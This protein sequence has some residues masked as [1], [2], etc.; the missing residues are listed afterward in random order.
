MMRKYV[1]GSVA[2]AMLLGVLSGCAGGAQP[3][4]SSAPGSSTAETGAPSSSQTSAASSQSSAPGELVT[5]RL[6][7][8]GV[9]A[10]SVPQ[11]VGLKHDIY[12]KY[13]IDLQVI[14]FVK[15]GAEAAAA[16][17]SG[18]V[19]MGSYGS[20]ILTAISKDVPI[21][22]VASPPNKRMDF[23]LTARNGIDKVEDLRGKTI[24]TGALGGGQHQSL[25]T[26]LRAHGLTEQDVNVVATGGA[27]FTMILGSGQVDAVEAGSIDRFR[28]EHEGFGHLLAE[29]SDYYENY[30][31][32]YIYATDAFI[33]AHPDAVT[34]FLKA[35]REVMQY[36]VDNLDEVVTAAKETVNLDEEVLG[37]YYEDTFSKW[38]LTFE[39]D[40]PGIANAVEILKGL[41]E[42]ESDVTFDAA[43]WVD[44][45]FLKAS[46]K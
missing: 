23:E 43:T 4:G 38:D 45:R 39:L 29:A 30:Q 36:A 33:S 15:G 17:A 9:G 32:S 11:D 27:D 21:K 10:A 2:A 40:P 46:Q 13:G 14:N 31:H 8:L 6:A 34:N 28:I 3:G 16:T 42:V 12:E 22:I 41:G 5:I 1:I 24:A 18:Q 25:V 44:D 37:S 26:I 35:H 19:D 20:P 7:N